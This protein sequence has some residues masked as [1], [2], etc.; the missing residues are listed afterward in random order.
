ML[1][2]LPEWR[3]YLNA[4]EGFLRSARNGAVKRP[5]VFTPVVV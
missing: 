1:A 4:G 2:T 5:N 3:D